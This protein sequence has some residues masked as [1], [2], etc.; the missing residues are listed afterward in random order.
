MGERGCNGMIN[1]QAASMGERGCMS[2]R[3][4]H[5][6]SM[7]VRGCMCIEFHTG[8]T[9]LALCCQFPGRRFT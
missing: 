9:K 7:G 5:A 6:A 8:E 2:K 4:L 3:A 1:L